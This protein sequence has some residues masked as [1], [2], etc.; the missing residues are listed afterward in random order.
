L[1][2]GEQRLDL[3]A[4]RIE[5]GVLGEVAFDDDRG[6]PIRALDGARTARDAEIGKCR[7]GY[8]RPARQLNREL[9]EVVDALPIGIP[10]REAQRELAIGIPAAGR[11]ASPRSRRWR[12]RWV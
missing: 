5:R 9:R 3:R 12:R 11:R 6:Q 10:E 1:V 7:K 4:H 8:A 2:V